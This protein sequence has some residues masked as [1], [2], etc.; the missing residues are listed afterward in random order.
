MNSNDMVSAPVFT[1]EST[2]YLPDETKNTFN[3]IIDRGN[4]AAFEKHFKL[5][6]CNTFEDLK[7]YGNNFYNL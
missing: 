4:A 3:V 6:E 2:E 7:N 1:R 5:S